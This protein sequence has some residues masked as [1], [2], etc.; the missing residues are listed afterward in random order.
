MFLVLKI[1][2]SKTTNAKKKIT[3]VIFR[4][5]SLFI[6]INNKQI[7]ENC[8]FFFRTVVSFNIVFGCG[9]PTYYPSPGRGIGVCS[10]DVQEFTPLTDLSFHEKHCK[11][12][13]QSWLGL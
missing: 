4:I 6:G 2:N 7:G 9:D 3:T 13:C 11:G 10:L 12:A 5:F 8:F 1:Y